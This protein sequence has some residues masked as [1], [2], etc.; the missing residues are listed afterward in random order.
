MNHEDSDFL[1]NYAKKICPHLLFIVERNQN[2]NIVVY[3]G[4]YRNGVLDMENP[5]IAEWIMFERASDGSAREKLNVMERKL[6]FG[7]KIESLNNN[8]FTM[9]VHAIPSKSLRLFIDPNGK[10]KAGVQMSQGPGILQRMFIYVKK[11]SMAKIPSVE[12]AV[13]YGVN[14][15]GELMQQT[16]TE[17]I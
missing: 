7:F 6:A 5:V 2:S 17:R 12:R 8:Q 15:K 14:M 3:S 1:Y 16:I 11:K 13:A 9:I 4:N 10:L